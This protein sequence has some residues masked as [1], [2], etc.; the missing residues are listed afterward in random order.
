MVNGNV[1]ENWPIVSDDPQVQAHY[2]LMRRRGES[3]N[4]AEICATGQMP[5]GRD[6]N[7]IL[8]E[9]SRSGED[10]ANDQVTGDRYRKICEEKGGST[11]GRKYLSQLA[12]FPGDPLAWVSDATDVRRVCELR[13]LECDGAVKVRRTRETKEHK[14][15]PIAD[16]IVEREVKQVLAAEP[17][18]KKERKKIREEVKDRLTPHWK[19]T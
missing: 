2:E 14:S 9:G 1:A 16:D 5:Y 3:H 18:R 6:E 13:N 11:T 8:F 10:F 17:H 12:E 15:I 7:K 19:K 4:I